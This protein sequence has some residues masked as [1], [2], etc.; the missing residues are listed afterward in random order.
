MEQVEYFKIGSIKLT[1]LEKNWASGH[2]LA[3]GLCRAPQ[4]AD[5]TRSEELR[6]CGFSLGNSLGAHARAGSTGP[7][8]DSQEGGFMEFCTWRGEGA[9]Y[10]HLY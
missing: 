6:F 1:Y 2:C 4:W 7:L 8:G 9:R 3:P 5:L 10:K